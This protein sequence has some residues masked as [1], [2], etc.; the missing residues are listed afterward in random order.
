MERPPGA[1]VTAAAS[2]GTNANAPTA[3]QAL[4]LP[5]RS[6]QPRPF[7]LLLLI[8]LL[9]I[10]FPKS[11]RRSKPIDE[12]SRGAY[13]PS[14]GR[15]RVRKEGKSERKGKERKQGRGRS[16]FGASGGHLKP[17]GTGGTRQ[18]QPTYHIGWYVNYRHR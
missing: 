6:P 18:T 9:F 15:M 3:A 5:L 7:V 4:A 14:K 2:R 8:L 16:H 13:I 1:P 12:L 11:V 10:R 17:A